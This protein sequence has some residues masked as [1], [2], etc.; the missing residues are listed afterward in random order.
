MQYPTPVLAGGLSDSNS[1]RPLIGLVS[2]DTIIWPSD[3]KRHVPICICSPSSRSQKA[4]IPISICY[5]AV[6]VARRVKSR[7]SERLRL[8][9]L[10]VGVESA[11]YVAKYGLLPTTWHRG[12]KFQRL[13]DSPEAL[14]GRCH[15]W[16]FRPPGSYLRSLR[17]SS[18]FMRWKYIAVFAVASEP[19]SASNHRLPL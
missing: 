6:L 16:P 13:T 7:I 2:M 15:S 1:R 18:W 10:F 8:A 14:L 17:V 4:K 12:F 3:S 9:A 19:P 5:R 11:T